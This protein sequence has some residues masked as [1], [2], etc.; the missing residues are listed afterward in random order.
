MVIIYSDECLRYKAAGHP[1]SPERVREALGALTGNFRMSEPD[2]A[3]ESDLIK[4][5]K[6]KHVERIRDRH[7]SDPDCPA[8]E[9]IY[10]YASLSAGGAIK[11]M[12]ER[13][14]SL[15][16]PPGHHAGRNSLGGFCYFNNLATAVKKSGLLTLIVDIDGHHGNGTED[17]FSGDPQAVYIS[18]HRAGTFPFS[19]YRS[20]GN[21]YNYPV[22]Q[23]CGDEKYLKILGEAL[24]KVSD[25][26]FEQLAVSAGFDTHFSDPLAS[27]GLSSSAYRSMGKMLSDMNL[28]VFSVL[29]GGYDGQA[30]G[31]N[32][33]SYLSGLSG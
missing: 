20:S 29:E 6:L 14:F 16:R 21:I 15:F 26:H 17:I 3:K 24:D 31:E 1:E 23:H 32:I 13:G 28:P 30:L 19:G 2:A 27:L 10:Y 5:H 4:A 11:A 9:N 7:F 12:E 25:K 8:Y 33:L 22:S 18:V